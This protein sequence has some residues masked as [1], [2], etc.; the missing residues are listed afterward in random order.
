MESWIDL[1]SLSDRELPALEQQIVQEQSRRVMNWIDLCRSTP[2][3]R[4]GGANDE[5]GCGIVE[6]SVKPIFDKKDNGDKNS[7]YSRY[8]FLRQWQNNSNPLFAAK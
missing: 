5:D 2:L 1:S 7:R 3:D 4:E 8:W 6:S